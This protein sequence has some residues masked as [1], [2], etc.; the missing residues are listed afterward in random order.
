MNEEINLPDES[1]G[2]A[3]DKP[4]VK[5]MHVQTRFA[6]MASRQ[7]GMPRSDALGRAETFIGNIEGKYPAWVN[8]DMEMLVA[9]FDQV[10]AEEG[11]TVETHEKTYR[12]AGRIRDL[13]GTF[14]Y[15]LTTSVGDSMCELI[16]R[17]A[18]GQTYSRDA[19]DAHVN[20]LHIVC[21]PQFKGVPL[22]SVSELIDSL[23]KMVNGFPDPDA[24]FK[25]KKERE[26]SRLK[27][28]A[29]SQ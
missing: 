21:T 27:K 12:L 6:A 29:N 23:S 1:S 25:A 11:F 17:L 13:G 20:A 15:N 24:V 26:R 2:D 7:G 16:F 18:E 4:E 8:K 9:Q 22:S 10:H 19:I 14:G 28:P 3:R 5:I